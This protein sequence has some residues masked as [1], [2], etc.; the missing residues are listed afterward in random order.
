MGRRAQDLD[1]LTDVQSDRKSGIITLKVSDHDPK[2]AAGLAQEYV[3]GL[4]QIVL[5][6]NTSSAHKEREFLE[7]R[8]GQVKGSLEKAERDFGDFASKNTAIDV[9]EQGKAMLG[10]AAEVE[11]QLIAAQTELESL[12]QIYTANNVPRAS[13]SGANRRIPAAAAENGRQ[14]GIFY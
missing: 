14:I 10:A 8:L 4:N 3:A 2:R 9:K 5:T 12:R 11:G 7:Q 1:K 6:L 13:G